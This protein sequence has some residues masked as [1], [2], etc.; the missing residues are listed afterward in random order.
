MPS[1]CLGQAKGICQ[2]T[3]EPGG[4]GSSPSPTIEGRPNPDSPSMESPALVSSTAG[5]VWGPPQAWVPYTLAKLAI[6][7]V[8]YPSLRLLVP[9]LNSQL[10]PLFPIQPAYILAIS[11]RNGYK[12]L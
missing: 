10:L 8:L 2:P 3:M 1:R 7:Y 6:C 9:G 4:Q 12:T 11:L 5:V